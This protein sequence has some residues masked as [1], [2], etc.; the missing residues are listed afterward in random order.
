MTAQAEGNGGQLFWGFAL[1]LVG[2]ALLMDRLDWPWFSISGRSWPLLL[3]ALGIYWVIE[4]STRHGRPPSRRFGAWLTYL[5]VWGLVNEFGYFGVDYRTSWPLLVVGAG[6][7]VVWRALEADR[8]QAH[9]AH[10]GH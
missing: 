5:G 7:N 3:M 2:V 8:Q 1:I 9:S 4:P 10:P 6:L